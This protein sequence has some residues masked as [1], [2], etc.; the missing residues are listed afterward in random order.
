[1]SVTESERHQIIQWFQEQMEPEQAAIMMK[2]IAPVGW[3]DIATKTDLAVIEGRL[4][5]EMA[6]I[7]GEMAE[8]RGDIKLGQAEQLRSMILTTVAS[9]VTVAS[10]VLAASQLT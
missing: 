9:N 7:R 2:V 5:G 6:G 10:L 8:L 1:M 3:G 4:R